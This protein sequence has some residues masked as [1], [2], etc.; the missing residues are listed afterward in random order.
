MNNGI[1]PLWALNYIPDTVLSNISIISYNNTE[2]EEQRMADV[3]KAKRQWE[4]YSG[5]GIRNL[6]IIVAIHI[7]SD[8]EIQ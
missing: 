5:E 6:S 4:E 7:E 1:Q 2:E 3:G 8:A